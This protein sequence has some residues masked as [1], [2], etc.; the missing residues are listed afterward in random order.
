MADSHLFGDYFVEPETPKEIKDSHLFGS[1]FPQE[2]PPAEAPK[3]A[4]PAPPVSGQTKEESDKINAALMRAPKMGSN[5]RRYADPRKLVTDLDE[6]AAELPADIGDAIKTHFMGAKGMLESGLGDVMQGNILPN[7]SSTNPQNWTAGGALKTAGGIIGMPGSLLSGPTQELVQN[8]LTKITGNPQFGERAALLAPIGGGGVGGQMAKAATSNKAVDALV[9]L[10]GADKVPA[11]I[12]RLKSNPTLRLADVS[13]EARVAAQGFGSD[14]GQPGAMRAVRESAAKSIAENPAATRQAYESTLGVRPQ[15]LDVL[16]SIKQKAQKVGEEQINPA[17]KGAKP[18]DLTSVISDIDSKLKP[19]V[20]GV[21]SQ[22]I[23]MELSPLQKEL[24]D[25]KGK[26]TDD[27][28]SVFFDPQKIHDIQA[29]LRR[30][31]EDL[32]SSAVGSERSL[33]RQLYD[34]RDKIVGAIDEASGGKYR[35]AL[36]AYK[37]AKDVGNAFERGLEIRRNRTGIKGIEEDSPE[38]LRRWMKD[39]SPEEIKAHQLGVIE[40]YGH[41]IDSIKHSARAGTDIPDIEFNLQ[42]M[43]ATFGKE[44]AD[45]LL[46]HMQDIKD[47]ATTNAGFIHGSKTAE[48]QA[49][50]KAFAVPEVGS[51]HSHISAGPIIGGLIGHAAG[52]S[53]GAAAGMTAIGG[54][55]LALQKLQQ[56][57]ALSRNA[58]MARLTGATGAERADLIMQLANHPKVVSQLN[59]ISGGRIP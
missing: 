40:A 2:E 52:G 9:G 31:A 22:D 35:P 25:I 53:A 26:L 39:A 7:T 34:V 15:A 42:K 14:P 47:K 8:P 10:V 5:P 3:N 56:V 21:V 13:P 48:T 29:E 11:A 50:Q 36:T 27:K 12:E 19:S 43:E 18:V 16:D 24:V 49:A 51:L 23:K 46:Q 20:R 45:A 17:I 4:A 30:R 58:E 28:G 57:S 1:Y 54:G 59:K 44:K 41:K 32:S 55:R 37:D 6:A 33:G 38:A